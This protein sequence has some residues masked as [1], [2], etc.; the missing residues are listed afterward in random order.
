MWEYWKKYA[1]VASTGASFGV[2]N[3]FLLQKGEN[4]KIDVSIKWNCMYNDEQNV[5]VHRC[6]YATVGRCILT[7]AWAKPCTRWQT[8]IN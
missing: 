7:V 4:L 2:R 3:V 1:T 8:W 6:Y 5:G